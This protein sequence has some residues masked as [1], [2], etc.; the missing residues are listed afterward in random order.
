MN[1]HPYV[2]AV[3]N[4]VPFI[5]NKKLQKFSTLSFLLFL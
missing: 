5:P 1:L 2:A 3:L 4:L